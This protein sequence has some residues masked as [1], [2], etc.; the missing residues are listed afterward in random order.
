MQ[1][2]ETAKTMVAEAVLD[3]VHQKIFTKVTSLD[4]IPKE[5]GDR[6]EMMSQ[7]ARLQFMFKERLRMTRL[8]VAGMGFASVWLS[9][10]LH[11]VLCKKLK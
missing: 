5:L 9:V 7:S 3:N 6:M 11:F 4:D 10:L 8:K 2:I 1:Q